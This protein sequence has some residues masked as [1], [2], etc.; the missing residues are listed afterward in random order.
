MAKLSDVLGELKLLPGNNASYDV[1]VSSTGIPFT[2]LK[3]LNGTTYYVYITNDGRLKVNTSEPTLGTE[4]TTITLTQ[5]DSTT[6]TVPVGTQIVDNSG[7]RYIYAQGV[8]NIDATHNWVSFD[9]DYVTT[10]LAA[11]AVGRVGV[12]M[13][14]IDATTKY[15]WFQV[16]GKSTTAATDAVATNKA[17]YID[18]TAGRVD[19]AAVTG[20]LVVG[21]WTRSTDA[22]TNIATVELNY[23]QVT[24]ILG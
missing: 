1:G 22:S 17:V 11:N 8:A 9:A 21:A 19:D 4:G 5:V 12:A 18:A 13:A 2:Q 23:P 7:N 14:V 24:D 10:L 6:P 20:D 15:G 16:Y 3:S